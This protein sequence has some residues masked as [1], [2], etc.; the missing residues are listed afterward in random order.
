MTWNVCLHSVSGLLAHFNKRFVVVVASLKSI[1]NR[2][3]LLSRLGLFDSL[4]LFTQKLIVIGQHE[5][6]QPHLA[7]YVIDELTVKP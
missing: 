3:P 6:G 2:L 4:L 7:H 1:W 5:F